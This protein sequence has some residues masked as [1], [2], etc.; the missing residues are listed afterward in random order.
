MSAVSSASNSP[1]IAPPISPESLVGRAES[2][3][4]RLRESQD[5][6]DARGHYSDE[7]HDEFRA[8][9][10]YRI[11]QPKLFGGLEL[12]FKTFFQVVTKIAEGHPGAAWCFCL[13][14][15]HSALLASYWGEEA[16]REF[17]GDGEFRACHRAIPAGTYTR[18]TG[19]YS[20]SGVWSYASGSPVSTHLALGGLIPDPNYRS[21]AINFFVPRDKVTIVD[22]WGGE[23]ALG[24]QSSGSNSVRLDDVFVPDHAFYRGDILFGQDTDWSKGTPGAILH[25]NPLYL[26]V[27]GGSYQL[28][29][30][31]IMH[32]AAR[33]A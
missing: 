28:C 23:R 13:S 3:I 1:F 26:G 15:S 29:F 18:A 9:G 19:G 10:F 16:Q 20:V 4:P 11:L 6:S 25:G 30:S 7:L 12:D 14:A 21:A 31:A 17:F 2:L 27:F 32:G 8:A 33:A 5:T 24:M 22:D